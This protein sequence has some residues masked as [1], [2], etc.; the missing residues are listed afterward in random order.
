MKCRGIC[1]IDFSVEGGFKEAAKEE[2]ALEAAIRDLVNGNKNVVHYQVE[3]RE[4]RGDAPPDLKKMKFR[5][6]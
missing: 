2:A 5:A 6:N 3:M 1:I 4:R